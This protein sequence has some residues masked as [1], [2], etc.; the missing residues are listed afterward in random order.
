MVCRPEPCR[1]AK[2]PETVLMKEAPN[3]EQCDATVEDDD[4]QEVPVCDRESSVWLKP[5]PTE[6]VGD[7]STKMNDVTAMTVLTKF[8]YPKAI[9]KTL[10][11]LLISKIESKQLKLLS[12]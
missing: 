12:S 11:C 2:Q 8:Q 1:W 10:E 6:N 3:E 9:V 7:P 5:L 4:E